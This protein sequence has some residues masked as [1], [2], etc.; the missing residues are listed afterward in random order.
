MNW[1]VVQ[2]AHQNRTSLARRLLHSTLMLRI[3]LLLGTTVF[4]TGCDASS[5]RSGLPN[6]DEG[7]FESQVYPILA[8]DCG[9]PACHGTNER[10]FRVFSPGRARLNEMTLLSE[11][12]TS[13][14]IRDALGRSLSMLADAPR[15]EESL[16][17]RK[18]LATSAG[19]AAHGG[20]DTFGRNV[21]PDRS[22]PA[23]QTLA[24]WAEG[25]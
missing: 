24:D 7:V 21:Y 1:S 23:W 6:L 2:L 4:A 15:V 18:P 22:D 5:V 25:N 3:A 13:E 11:A 10:A 17:L 19:G 14:E 8:R 20:V 9:F 16:L 12:P